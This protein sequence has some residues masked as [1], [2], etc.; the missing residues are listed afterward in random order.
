M[1]NLSCVPWCPLSPSA[2][3]CN[4]EVKPQPLLGLGL[5]EII[6]GWLTGAG[7]EMGG[8][9]CVLWGDRPSCQGALMNWGS[10]KEALCEGIENEKRN[11]GA[12]G[13]S[14]DRQGWKSNGGVG[15]HDPA[16]PRDQGH[17]ANT[18]RMPSH[19]EH[20]PGQSFALSLFQM[21][22]NTEWIKASRRQEKDSRDVQ[23]H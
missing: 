4:R 21:I 17:T 12:S 13:N 8:V 2:S 6:V 5:P 18:H 22:N 20:C 1:S 9:W 23:R 7:E 16:G 19:V 15:H 14:D 10:L 11:G 3:H